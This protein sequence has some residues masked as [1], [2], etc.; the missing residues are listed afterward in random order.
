MSMYIIMIQYI[1]NTRKHIISDNK[2]PCMGIHLGHR[3]E[4]LGTI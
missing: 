2:T 1:H 4:K 3:E